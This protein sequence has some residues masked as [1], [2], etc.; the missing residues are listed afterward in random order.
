M[1]P[2]DAG[3]ELTNVTD[4]LILLAAA[5]LDV[6]EVRALR[7]QCCRCGAVA[8]HGEQDAR[9]QEPHARAGE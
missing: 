9:H 4:L 1:R 3:D 5:Q 8:L 2:R 7:E 6:T